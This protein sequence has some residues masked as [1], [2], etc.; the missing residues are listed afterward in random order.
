MSENALRWKNK[1][2]DKL[3]EV[4]QLSESFAKQI[5]LLERL[6]VRVSLAAEGLDK[7]L[8]IE[9]ASLRQLIRQ[10]SADTSKLRQQLEAIEERVLAMDQHQQHTTDDLHHVLFELLDN[11]LS[12][13]SK[14][15]S[16]KALKACQKRLVK[17]ATDLKQ[18]A[19][20]LSEISNLQKQVL[21]E[22]GSPESQPNKDGLLGR[23]F[24]GNTPSPQLTP[25]DPTSASP[26]TALV[27]EAD[28]D[29]AST[30]SVEAISPGRDLS[31]APE[32][33]TDTNKEV[34]EASEPGFAAIA[35]HVCATLDELIEQLQFPDTMTKDASKVRERIGAGLNWSELVP[36]LDDIV[37]LVIAAFG[38]EQQDFESFLKV[39]DDRL[40]SIQA[41]L[42][43]DRNSQS[44][45]AQNKSELQVAMQGHV[46]AI[47]QEVLTTDDMTQLK[48]TVQADLDAI[49]VSL[50]HFMEKENNREQQLMEQM[51]DLQGR[52][53]I[54][55]EDSK[56][57]QQQ[58]I[59]QQQK[60]LT[61]GLTGL[62]N[63]VAYEQRVQLEFERSQRYGNPLTLVIADI[64]KFKRINDN[65]GHLSGDKVIQLIGKEVAGRIR[66]TDFIARYGGEE[67]VIILPE[68]NAEMAF[69][70]MDKSREL[71]A[72]MPFHFQN[73]K[74]QV[75][76]SMG[77]CEFSAGADID[78]VFECA[79]Q[80]LYKAKE[81]GRNQVQRTT[82]EGF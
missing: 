11:L 10:D 46:N 39:L 65:Y 35:E 63:R 24:G 29:Q 1:Y 80:A 28:A 9:L 21:A 78:R 54:M 45:A 66:K 68:T 52:L 74:V 59:T 51:D 6:L 12:S 61:D 77:L 33:K 44:M 56:E 17:D 81:A 27:T 67:F 26:A 48:S 19:A 15:T 7:K 49:L 30:A 64:D 38:K 3:D 82:V 40:L 25:A 20:I 36:T 2:L 50:E 34:S 76:I 62:P 23:L 75:T 53:Q 8:D 57:M 32:Q 31:T 16:R 13:T 72:R 47:Q 43:I 18:Q 73:E 42:T 22:S 14:R 71:I 69:K 58:L 5:N 79:D 60:A 55:E 41:F 4:D 70:V 37:N